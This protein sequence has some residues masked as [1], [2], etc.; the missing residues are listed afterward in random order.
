MRTA[1]EARA[2]LDSLPPF[3][4]GHRVRANGHAPAGDR[5]RA[6]DADLCEAFFEFPWQFTEPEPP[7]LI[8]GLLAHGEEFLVY[9]P[10]EAGK[11]FFMVDLACRWATGELWRGR[12]VDR[13]LVIYLAGERSESIKRRILAWAKRNGVPPA[14]IPVAVLNTSL[15]LLSPDGD[16][17][18][19]LGEA[20][21]AARRITGRDA[22]AIIADTIHSLSPGSKEDNHSFGVLMGQCRKL[23]DAIGQNVPPALG[24]V[25]HTGKDEERGPR[26]GNSITAAVSL[27]MAISVRLEK[28]RLVEIDKGSDLAGEKPHIEPFVIDDVTLRIM[29]DGTPVKSGVHVAI[30]LADVPSLSDE[31]LKRIAF[32]MHREGKSQRTIAKA[33]NRSL[34]CVNK[35]LN[36]DDDKRSRKGSA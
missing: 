33:I 18:D 28:Y 5:P 4:P 36:P 11:S 6:T 35:W 23:R 30:T 19:R 14:N 22:I 21:R 12:E 26:G 34:G 10:P 17:L 25:H 32:T 24:Y 7:K 3:A 16:E 2:A 1:D 13:G 29:P 9:G 27:S 15:N 31:E 20:I 8:Q